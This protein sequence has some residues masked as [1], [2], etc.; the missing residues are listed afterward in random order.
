MQLHG[1][2]QYTTYTCTD[3]VSARRRCSGAGEFQ[4]T[5]NEPS[6]IAPHHAKLTTPIIEPSVAQ[7][8][9]KLIRSTIILLYH[10]THTK[11]HR[12]LL[13]PTSSCLSPR[14]PSLP[15]PVHR[16]AETCPSTYLKLFGFPPRSLAVQLRACVCI[17]SQQCMTREAEAV[18]C[19]SEMHAYLQ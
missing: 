5:I 2:K 8:Q 17:M 10:S 7:V 18:M 12:T 3:P 16:A 19:S 4:G 6:F 14:K 1:H 15:I 9:D 13:K 11:Q